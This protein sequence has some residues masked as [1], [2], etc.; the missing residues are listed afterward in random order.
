MAWEEVRLAGETGC[1]VAVLTPELDRISWL[2]EAAAPLL[3]EPERGHDPLAL[4]REFAP[5]LSRD[6]E[7][8]LRL[9][10]DLRNGTAH[11]TVRLAL[12]VTQSGQL[13]ALLSSLHPVKAP[14]QGPFLARRLLREAGIAGKPAL[15]AD[16]NG[17]VVQTESLPADRAEEL[18][19][20]GQEFLAG[21]DAYLEIA[22]QDQLLA[23]A[24]LSSSHALVCYREASQPP[25]P[26]EQPPLAKQASAPDPDAHVTPMGHLVQRWHE[27]LSE[28]ADILREMAAESREKLVRS[29]RAVPSSQPPRQ[30]ASEIPLPPASTH[31]LADGPV[32]FA[33]KID[34][35]YR[36]ES[37]GSELAQVVGASAEGLEGRPFSEVADQLNLDP[38]AEIAQLLAARTTWSGRIVH[39]PI[40]GTDRKA[41]VELAALPVFGKG[42]EFEGVRGF[43]TIR[44]EIVEDPHSPAF[45]E[46]AL[47]DAEAEAFASIGAH[48]RIEAPP[49]PA[50]PDEIRLLLEAMPVAVLLQLRD[51]LVFA[52][53]SFLK[54]AAFDSVEHLTESGGL[55]YL[56]AEPDQIPDDLQHIRIQRA[57]GSLARASCQMQRLQLD[58]QSY[59]AFLFQK[60]VQIEADAE[61]AGELR[62]VLDTAADGILLLSEDGLVRSMNGSAEALFDVAAGQCLGKPLTDLMA[63]ESRQTVNDYLSLLRDGGFPGLMNDGREVMGQVAQG[64]LLSL[65]ITIGR[66]GAGRGWCVV[67]RDIGHWKRIE[68]ELIAERGKAED[69]SLLK[70]RFLTNMSH[71]LRTPLNAIIGFADV[72]ASESFGPIG[73]PRY[74]QYLHDIKKSGH[75]LLDLVNDLLDISKIEAGKAHLDFQPVSIASV[76]SDAVALM[77][78]QAGRAKVILRTNLPASLPEVVADQRSIK[79]IALNVLSNAIRFT[80][81]GGQVLVSVSQ[82]N[83]GEISLRFRDTGIGM[84]S[85]EIVQAMTP[86]QQVNTTSRERGDG[87]GLGLS[88]TKALVEANS[89][90]FTIHS[91]PGEGTLVEVTFP[92]QRVLTR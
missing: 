29:A 35:D 87:T 10:G 19:A 75:H 88:L 21:H 12:A 62:A 66:L 24:R 54:L 22:D 68:E 63:Q 23:F 74:V 13:F 49:Q 76:I 65:F 41:V 11:V 42:A 34:A 39:W 52:N 20:A 1:A 3:T 70:S 82:G 55:E 47:S 61:D 45:E 56:M 77:Q 85:D 51:Q 89:A 91:V 53:H 73:N 4:L 46:K 26:A 80:P 25:L 17:T 43:G 64:G 69:A 30:P 50:L 27:R 9:P 15:I 83:S 16:A 7:V 59:L 38:K 48:L 79:Q 37:V 40:G 33:W 57:D 44:S 81:S 6:G 2:N 72:M 8:K 5:A 18:A 36:F 86:F 84:N 31:K 71:E 67:I 58:G 92:P 60:P 78:T 28:R 32:R 90:S 14:D